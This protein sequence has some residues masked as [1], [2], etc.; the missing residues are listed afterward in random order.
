MPTEAEYEAVG[1]YDPEMLNADDRLSLLNWLSDRGFTLQE[2]REGA[3]TNALTRLAGDR[4]LSGG[5]PASADAIATYG[6]DDE[7]IQQLSLAAGISPGALPVTESTLELFQLFSA[8]REMFS[9]TSALHFLRVMGSSLGRIAE[10]ANMMFL[11]D[12]ELPIVTE[13]ASQFELAKSMVEALTLLQG[14]DDAIIRLFRLHMHDAVV[15]SRVAREF[16]V[17]QELVP[18]V[19]GFVDLVGFTPITAAATTH[20]LMDLVLEFEGQAYDLVTEHGG[21]V[22][23]FIGDE[24]MFTTVDPMSAATIVQKMFSGLRSRDVTPRAGM[25]YGNVLP[26]GGDYYGSIV[27]LASRVADIAVPFEILVTGDF[28][29]KLT[30]EI[31]VAPA[32]R[33]MLKGFAEPIDLYSLNH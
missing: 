21:R 15:R 25:A 3:D 9:D 8:A 29:A 7:Y 27:N 19:I 33:R 32:G 12:V 23:K 16:A 18:M 11:V 1:A 14:L 28:V 22:V 26:H 13:H 5:T 2:I 10:A 20:E 30:T 6:F 4:I 24:V 17:E 31:T